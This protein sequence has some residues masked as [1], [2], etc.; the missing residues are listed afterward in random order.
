MQNI[1]KYPYYISGLESN[2]FFR[3][4]FSMFLVAFSTKNEYNGRRKVRKEMKRLVCIFLLFFLVG[5]GLP[6]LAKNEIVDLYIAPWG[7]DR[8]AGDIHTPFAT[9]EKA[10]NTAR[11]LKKETVVHLRGGEYTLQKTFVLDERDSRTTYRAYADEEV[12][13]RGATPLISLSGSKDITLKDLS[14]ES[15][16]G[17]RAQDTLRLCVFHCRF[18]A[19]LEWLGGEQGTFSYNRTGSSGVV[20][21]EG[22]GHTVS[23]NVLY[24]SLY[25]DGAG[26]LVQRNLLP[27]S[28]DFAIVCGGDEHDLRQNRIESNRGGI[29]LAGKKHRVTENVFVATKPKEDSCGIRLYGRYDQTEITDNLLQGFRIGISFVGGAAHQIRGNHI[30]DCKVSLRLQAQTAE[31]RDHFVEKNFL[32]NSPAF[33]IEKELRQNSTIEPGETVEQPAEGYVAGP[34]LLSEGQIALCLNSPLAL[35]NGDVV[36]V[37]E[38]NPSVMPCLI[39]GRTMVPL[40]FV[41]ER[42]GFAVAWEESTQTVQLSYGEDVLCL[43]IGSLHYLWN[44]TEVALD[45]PAQLVQERTFLPI[46]AVSE[47]FQRKVAWDDR[48]LVVIGMDFMEED[49]SNYLLQQLSMR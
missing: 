19:G 6:V 26:H 46:R 32:Y 22:K 13:L 11:L 36:F 8:S 27:C 3:V 7:N 40:R 1:G 5:T 49:L 25:L 9:L 48:G 45:V 4:A 41:A 2:P 35:A 28:A 18:S 31:D 34:L 14:L 37:D 21:I 17:I 24:N 44:G 30:E 43:P 42:L 39:E 12:L 33:E 16:R 10:R 38:E 15:L 20:R 23:D 29:Q 47:A